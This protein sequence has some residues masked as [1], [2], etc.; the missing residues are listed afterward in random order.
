MTTKRMCK[1]HPTKEA[2]HKFGREMFACSDCASTLASQWGPPTPINS[3]PL[4]P[5]IKAYFGFRGLKHANALQA[6]GW[7]MSELGECHEAEVVQNTPGWV[8]NNPKEEKANLAHECGDLLMMLAIYFYEIGA[9]GDTRQIKEIDTMDDLRELCENASEPCGKTVTFLSVF[10]ELN[11]FC[12][13][14][15]I[16]PFLSLEDKLTTKQH[17]DG[18]FF[19]TD[20]VRS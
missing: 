1:F 16:N 19:T 20:Y 12:R 6:R 8:R 11:E 13:M 3:T 18:I 7:I 17:A 2:T 10:N 15:N 9:V 4:I 14:Y 5:M